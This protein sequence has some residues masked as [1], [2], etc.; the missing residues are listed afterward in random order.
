MIRLPEPHAS[1]SSLGKDGLEANSMHPRRVLP[2]PPRP[3]ERPD[4]TQDRGR[5][6]TPL[7][8]SNHPFPQLFPVHGAAHRR[9]E[10]IG[11]DEKARAKH[12]SISAS[13]LAAAGALERAGAHLDAGAPGE[14]LDAVARGGVEDLDLFGVIGLHLGAFVG[15]KQRTSR[16]ARRYVGIQR[17]S[18]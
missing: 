14:L 8:L 2:P 12:D 10:P 7:P 18:S 4:K 9:L 3:L 1:D 17:G 15:K 13:L 6:Q 5:R 11:P 16:K